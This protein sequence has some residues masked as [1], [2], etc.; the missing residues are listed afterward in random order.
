MLIISA[1]FLLILIFGVNHRD[2][3]D[4]ASA[5]SSIGS[6][7][8]QPA[9]TPVINSHAMKKPIA[10]GRLVIEVGLPK[11]GTTSMFD[12]F[13]KLG[14][15][16]THYNLPTK[17]CDIGLNGTS[18]YP[19]EAVTV[20]TNNKP[21]KWE[22]IK[23]SDGC[24]VATLIQKSLSLGLKPFDL[25]IETGARKY[26][27]PFQGFF[28]IDSCR[29]HP[30]NFCRIMQADGLDQL[31]QAYP[32]ALYIL[33]VRRTLEQQVA[34]M[35]AWAD[36]LNRYRSFGYF[37]MFAGQS[38][39]KSDTE[40]GA[41]MIEGLENIT[42]NYFLERPKLNFLEICLED[43][44]A[45][46]KIA[47]FAGIESFPLY[48][49]NSGTYTRGKTAAPTK[50]G[51]SAPTTRPAENVGEPG[52]KTAV[53]EAHPL[54]AK[55]MTLTATNFSRKLIIEV[56]LPRSGSN[57]VRD[58]LEALGVQTA[59]YVLPNS[60]CS[61]TPGRAIVPV[62]AVNVSTGGVRT[63][64]PQVNVTDGCY[65]G[66]FIQKAISKSSPPFDFI[67]QSGINMNVDFRGYFQLDICRSHPHNF[68]M[69]PQ[70]FALDQ[71]TDAYPEAYYILNRRANTMHQVQS[72]HEESHHKGKLR[73][74][75]SYGYIDM[76]TQQTVSRR[77]GEI[78]EQQTSSA[79]ST[80]RDITALLQDGV[81]MM[82]G[83]HNITR[84]YFLTTKPKLK[85][86]EVSV[87]DVDAAAILSTFL[88]IPQL[89]LKGHQPVTADR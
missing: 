20:T 31:T 11:S 46:Q 19:I 83:M 7:M 50:Q 54:G 69:F 15:H 26:N 68:C 79:P 47:S 12:G 58:S 23:A 35:N 77:T 87:D 16:S 2:A 81:Q 13:I 88:D 59:H 62:N 27:Q 39:T 6:I 43:P 85:F 73:L 71:L 86:L 3:I 45:A 42:R 56:G 37:K 33:N 44:E 51:V 1:Y 14:M 80:T 32:D 55:E 70:V 74:Y 64:W 82:D 63:Y 52:P 65:V 72:L 4:F 25:I 18:I 36:M 41:L 84:N 30:W 8:G 57:V 38:P 78:P 28:Q 5:I 67:Y 66:L 76:F 49:K 60:F 61:T 34:S 53:P 17:Y 21:T 48:H 22:E 29:P 89:K 40:N 10:G 9:A 24:Y 75:E